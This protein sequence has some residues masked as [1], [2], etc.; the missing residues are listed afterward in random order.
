MVVPMVTTNLFYDPVFKDGGFT[1]NDRD[2]APVRDAQGDAQHGS[3]RRAGRADLCVLGRPGR[4]GGRFRQRRPGGAG[5]VSG[6]DGHCSPSTPS[7]RAT[8]CGSRSSRSRT[9]RAATSCCPPIGHALAFI[10]ELE[11]A[12]MVG[13]NPEIGHEQMAS[14]NYTHGI[15]QAL[16]AGQAVP[17]RPERAEGPPLRPGPGLRLRRS[18]AGVLHRRSAGERR[19]RRRADLRR[20]SAFRL[21]AAAHRE[22]GRGL[23]VRPGQHGALPD[24][25]GA[26]AGVPGRPGG[27]GG[28]RRPRGWTSW[29]SP[30]SPRARPTSSCLPTAARSRTTTSTAA[31]TQG[32]GFARLQRLALEHLLGAR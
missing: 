3:G 20:G 19:A 21:Q 14:L 24:A 32:Y 15:A 10:N 1:S 13:I 27:A 29:P 22:H 28:A 9:S 2:G 16:W 5:P 6:G 23:G 30:R 12:D 11:H 31:R 18:A 26:G 8:G 25:A 4:L 17:H 7:S